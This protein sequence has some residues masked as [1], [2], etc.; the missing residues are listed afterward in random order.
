ML[1]L[2]G[3]GVQDPELTAAYSSSESTLYP[4][5]HLHSLVHKYTHMHI[6]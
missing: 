1:P 3:T 5:E 6:T 2:Q 4:L